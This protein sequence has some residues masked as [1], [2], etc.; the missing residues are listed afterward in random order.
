[1]S[2]ITV[3]IAS[4]SPEAALICAAAYTRESPGVELEFLPREADAWLEGARAATG[5]YI[6]FTSDGYEPHPGWWQAAVA[7]AD[8]KRV[9]APLIWTRD[10]S[11]PG[12]AIADWDAC[13][14]SR[15]PF[16]SRAQLAQAGPPLELDRWPS[17]ETVFRTNYAFTLIRPKDVT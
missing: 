2:D 15:L 5:R 10:G 8:A 7:A 1:M 9:P 11:L 6:H 13:P 3:V 12:E 4:S 17:L 14:R 16:L